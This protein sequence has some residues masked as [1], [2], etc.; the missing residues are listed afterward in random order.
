MHCPAQG[1]PSS[2]LTS[3][4]VCCSAIQNLL[5]AVSQKLTKSAFPGDMLKGYTDR[6]GRCTLHRA[7]GT[8]GTLYAVGPWKLAST[9]GFG[10]GL[11]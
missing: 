8:P 11:S 1:L 5:A 9:L 3:A 7:T 6:M 4:I 2:Q 10:K